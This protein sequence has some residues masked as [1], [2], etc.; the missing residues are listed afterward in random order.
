[1]LQPRPLRTARETFVSSRSSLSNARCRTRFG[2]LQ[3]QAMDLTV[4]TPLRYAPGADA[5]YGRMLYQSRV[6]QFSGVWEAA[7][8]ATAAVICFASSVGLPS[9]L[10]TKDPMEVSLPAHG[11]MLPTAQPLSAPL[12]NGVRFFHH[13]LPD[14]PWAYLAVRCPTT[15]GWRAYHVSHRCQSRRG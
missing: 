6:D 2:H 11:V 4:A 9:S 13:P 5:Q 14:I 8:A 10:V 3:T 1:M 7:P 15:G 12:Q